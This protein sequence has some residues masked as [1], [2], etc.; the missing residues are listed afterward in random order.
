M[1]IALRGTFDLIG[2][3]RKWLADHSMGILGFVVT[4]TFVPIMLSPTYLTRWA[5]IAIGV[6]LLATI[7]PRAVRGSV[8]WAMAFLLAA[9]AMATTWASPDP[10]GG[11]LE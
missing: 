2:G 4:S 7:D 10:M 11:Y 9:A 5:A 1:D 6:P 8:L 3:A